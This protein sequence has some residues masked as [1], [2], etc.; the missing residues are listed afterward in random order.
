LFYLLAGLLLATAM[1]GSYDFFLMQNNYPQIA[2]GAFVSLAVSVFY[3]LK[4]IRL[5]QKSSPHNYG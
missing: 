1:H 5:H 3:S 4:A 2:M